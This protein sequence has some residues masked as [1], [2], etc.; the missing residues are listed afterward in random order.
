MLPFFY[1]TGTWC[2]KVH[3]KICGCFYNI[4]S[5]FCKRCCFLYHDI[6]FVYVY[7]NHHELL[8]HNNYIIYHDY[9]GIVTCDPLI[10]VLCGYDNITVIDFYSLDCFMYIIIV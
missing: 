1:D 9:R 4:S 3:C 2:H 5:S 8:Y 7:H 10:H 6:S